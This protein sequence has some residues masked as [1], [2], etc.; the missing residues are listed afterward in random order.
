[1]GLFNEFDEVSHQQWTEKIIKDL[2][3]KDFNENLVWNSIEGIAVQPFYNNESIKDNKSKTYH[4]NS[5]N[6]DIENR[7]VIAIDSISK[8]NEKALYALSR[9]ANSIQFENKIAS[10]Q[11]FDTLL[12]NIDITII[13][14]HFYNATPSQTVDFL[15]TYC[16]NKNINPNH[17]NGSICYDYLGELLISGDWKESQNK[18]LDTLYNISKESLPFKTLAINGLYFN[19]AGAT[20]VQELAYT[21]SQAV[22]YLNYLTEK[23]LDVKTIASSFAFNFGIG[24]NYFF[25]IAKIRAAKILWNL[26]LKAYNVDST[27]IYINSTSTYSNFACFD[28]HNNILRTTTEAMSAI[29]GGSNSINLLPFDEILDT[30][31][32]LSDRIAINI[33][34]IINEEAFLNKVKDASK[35][36]YYIESLTDELVEKSLELFKQLEKNG[37]FLANIKNGFIQDSIHQVAKQKQAKYNTGENTLLGV[38]KHKS[39]EGLKMVPVVGPDK[40][41]KNGIIQTLELVRFA[42]EIESKEVFKNA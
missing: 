20:S 23:K 3:G 6:A 42:R 11:D 30:S 8:A 2:K 16:K 9:G 12:T 19:N 15:N 21:F 24:S 18:D 4:F 36:S 22:E 35:G 25:E 27:P 41:H 1:M 10:Q 37:G 28:Q 17:L 34:H 13:S 5:S 29:I 26:I 33:T 31:T 32:N 7:V 40:T 39:N 38:N 14:L